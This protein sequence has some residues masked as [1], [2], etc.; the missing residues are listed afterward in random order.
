M[1]PILTTIKFSWNGIEILYWSHA[2]I[3]NWKLGLERGGGGWETPAR[4]VGR[5]AKFLTPLPP[6]P[7]HH[8]P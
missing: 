1:M 6:L 5:T 8:F 3:W 4:E 2:G 7:T